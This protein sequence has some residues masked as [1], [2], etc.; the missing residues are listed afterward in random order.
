M[1]LFNYKFP[2]QNLR[3][4]MTAWCAQHNI[5]STPLWKLISN[6]KRF[7]TIVNKHTEE[8]FFII[9][10]VVHGQKL[11][12]DFILTFSSNKNWI[13]KQYH[14]LD[15]QEYKKAKYQIIALHIMAMG[16]PECKNHTA[17]YETCYLNL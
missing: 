9:I 17:L 7:T 8:D 13:T 10:I 12:S 4:E 16:L 6:K 14:W 15:Y 1:Y 11:S 5:L 3:E 2:S